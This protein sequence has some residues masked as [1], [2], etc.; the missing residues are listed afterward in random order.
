MAANP[1]IETL[2]TIVRSETMTLAEEITVLSDK[3]GDYM[4]DLTVAISQAQSNSSLSTSY[5]N[6]LNGWRDLINGYVGNIFGKTPSE[7]NPEA[8][9]ILTI[10]QTAVVALSIVCLYENMPPEVQSMV[11]HRN[12]FDTLRASKP[13]LLSRAIHPAVAVEHDNYARYLE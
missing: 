7:F 3:F 12:V 13:L 11:T 8:H 1:F 9:Q 10:H 4:A 6:A 2:P 5:L